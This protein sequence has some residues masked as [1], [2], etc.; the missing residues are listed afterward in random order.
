MWT[1]TGGNPG[2]A[3]EKLAPVMIGHAGIATRAVNRDALATCNVRREIRGKFAGTTSSNPSAVRARRI[4]YIRSTTTKNRFG[5]RRSQPNGSVYSLSNTTFPGGFVPVLRKII[6]KANEA[7][8]VAILRYQRN[9]LL[10]VWMLVSAAN[11]MIAGTKRRTA[12][13][14]R[15]YEAA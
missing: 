11:A 10:T 3:S 9:R 2:L 12:S 1:C 5:S 8:R 15:W 14:A 6:P 4:A 13:G 7:A